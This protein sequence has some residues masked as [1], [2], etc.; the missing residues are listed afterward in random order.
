MNERLTAIVG[1]RISEFRRKMAE[2]K[3]IAKTVP[4]KIFVDIEARTNKFQKTMNRVSN[5]I[6]SLDTVMANAFSGSLMMVSPATVPLIAVLVGLL[7]SLGPMLG[8]I[9]AST[10]ALATAFGFA[11]MAALAFGGAAIPT[12]SKLFDENAKLNKQQKI[13]KDSL[14]ELKKTW[15]GIT[16]D[17]EKPVLE[18]FTKSMGITNKVLKMSKPMFESSATAVNNLL[19]SLNKSLDSSPV[20]A[21]FDYMNKNAGPMLETTG[22][23]IGN[24]MQGFMNMMV[25]F[26]PLAEQTAQGFLKMSSGF[27]E[28]AAGLS[29]SE[30][31]QSFVSYVQENMPKVRAIFRDAIAGITYFFAAFGPLS[32]DMMTGLQGLMARFKQW[33]ATLG[34]NQQF[35]Q[36][37]GYIRDNAPRV[38]ELIGNLASFIVN[39]GIALAPLGTKILDIVNNILAW[40]NGMMETHPWVG[41]MIGVI[42]LLAGGFQALLPAII[43]GRVLFAGFGTTVAG[44]ITKLMPIFNA[45]KINMIAG[46]KVLGTNVA[47]TATRFGTALALMGTKIKLWGALILA[48]LKK[49]LAS[50]LSTMAKMIASAASSAAKFAVHAAKVIAQWALMAAKSLLHAGKM[51]ASWVVA[52]GPVGWVIATVVA[53]VALIIANWS[54]VKSFTVSAWNNVVSAI[55]SAISKAVSSIKTGLN[56]ALS[57][58]KGLGSSFFNAGKGF[59]DMMAK[60]ITGAIG[61]VTGAVKNVAQ[62]VRNF[63][64]FSPAKEGPLSDLD[65]LN[66]AGPIRDSIAKAKRVTSN[67]MSNLTSHLRT[68]LDPEI[69][70]TDLKENTGFGVGRKINR[71]EEHEIKSSG[72]SANDTA[73]NTSRIEQLLELIANNK[74]SIVLDTGALVGGTINEIDRAGGN[75]IV[76]TERWGR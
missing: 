30:K 65:K 32:A 27:A 13:A 6:H 45:F 71:Q 28:W 52:M 40:T 24:F 34:E 63:L 8:V 69:T 31:F 19:N 59:I 44:W 74:Q 76:L 70:M 4:N 22:K 66:F 5:F 68:S 36:F 20:K 2:V 14:T 21:F 7:G 38:I 1:A 16:K 55:K 57:F 39:L 73:N 23:T 15:N 35:Q 43:A 60:G 33:A 3:K 47:S 61:K 9:G 46:L 75:K 12:I 72:S 10:F 26:G 11:G 51:A 50:W 58:V 37:I 48:Q 56:S 53:L 18:A 42:L 67:A 25:A 41:K 29:E 62:K 54:K 17:L 49:T 64:P